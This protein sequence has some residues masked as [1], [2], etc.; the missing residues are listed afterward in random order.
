M[1]KYGLYNT[2]TVK[3][4]VNIIQNMH[5][6]TTW[7]EKLFPARLDN[8]YLSVH[9]AVHYAINYILYLNTSKEK[10]MKHMNSL[11]VD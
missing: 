5:N 10:Y 3:K 2:E 7:N 9:G 6:K 1:I 4:I 8:W 11:Y